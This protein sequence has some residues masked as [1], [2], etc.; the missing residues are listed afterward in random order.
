MLAGWRGKDGEKQC[1]GERNPRQLERYIAN[2]CFWRYEL[3]DEH[4]FYRH[5]NKGYLDWAHSVGFIARPTR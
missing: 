4:K 2:G 1:V 5:A 3:P